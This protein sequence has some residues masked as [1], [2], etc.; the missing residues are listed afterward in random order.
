MVGGSIEAVGGGIG[1]ILTAE[2]GVGLAGGVALLL[3]GA[4][5]AYAGA[6]QMWTGKAKLHVHMLALNMHLKI[7]A[8]EETADK[9]ATTVDVGTSLSEEA[10]DYT[11]AIDLSLGDFKTC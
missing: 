4:D 7:G 6:K 10:L 8:S 5:N 1:G 9:I 2:T 3:H 11:K